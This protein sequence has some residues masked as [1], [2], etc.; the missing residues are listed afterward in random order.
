MLCPI[1][2]KPQRI[3]CGPLRDYTRRLLFSSTKKGIRYS[4]SNLHP[5]VELVCLVTPLYA[6]TTSLSS[7]NYSSRSFA[8][9]KTLKQGSK[10]AGNLSLEGS[11]ETIRSE[12]VENIKHVSDHAPTHQKPIGDLN[13][14]DYLAGLIDGDGHFSV[15]QQLIISFHSFDASLAYSLKKR[16]GFGNVYKVKSKKALKL[17][18]A[19][20]AGVERV[21]KLVNGKLRTE[22]KY[23][24][25]LNNILNHTEYAIFRKTTSFTLNADPNLTG[26]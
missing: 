6:G 11:S 10:S 5:E 21:V 12:I 25:V 9:V 24:Q 18:I 16:L 26:Y 14:G 2:R 15:Q 19:T 3:R 23:N 4:P 17:V 7:F 1:G 13:F 22:N 8:T 20:R